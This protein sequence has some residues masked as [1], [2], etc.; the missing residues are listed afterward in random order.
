MNF[1]EAMKLAETGFDTWAS[2]QHNRKWFN[3]IDGTPIKNDLLVNIAEAIVEGTREKVEDDD[4]TH[5]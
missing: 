1:M 2:M 5:S 3:R 4:P